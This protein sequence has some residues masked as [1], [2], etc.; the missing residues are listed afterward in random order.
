M[1]PKKNFA[2]YNRFYITKNLYLYT[3]NLIKIL[4]IMKKETLT[5]GF[6]RLWNS[7]YPLMMERIVEIVNKHNPTHL[8][9]DKAYQR[10]VAL[11]P[12]WEQIQVQAKSSGITNQIT[13]TDDLR[14][15]LTT[16]IFKQVKQYKALGIEP[17]LSHAKTLDVWTKKYTLG[18]VTENYTSQTEKTTQLVQEAE[19]TPELKVSLHAL[20]LE[21]FIIKLK[22]T[23]TQFE[24]LFRNRTEEIAKIPSIDIRAI[25]KTTDDA[26]NKLFT[27]I[28]FCKEEYEELDYK[29]LINELQELL[30]YHKTQIKTRS[31]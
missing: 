27:A 19:T 10:L 31:K 1:A 24:Q 25:R 26:V 15:R 20:G 23:N 3:D 29:P 9:L 13:E 16:F 18:L 2:I 30:N 21:P 7:E 5:F 12:N 17:H 4:D 11:R 28:L 6:A 22:E 14:D 8:H